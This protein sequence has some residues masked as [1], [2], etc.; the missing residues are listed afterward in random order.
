MPQSFERYVTCSQ[1]SGRRIENTPMPAGSTAGESC[2]QPDS[3]TTIRSS[4][5][6]PQPSSLNCRTRVSLFQ[7]IVTV[8]APARKEF[9]NNSVRMDC[10]EP[11]KRGAFFRMDW[12]TPILRWWMVMM[13]FE[14]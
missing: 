13:L 4:G 14:S 12:D 5:L 6:Q 10:G 11:K 2:P 9:W 7:V 1:Y 3:P 8:F